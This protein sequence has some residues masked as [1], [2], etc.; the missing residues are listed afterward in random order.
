[1]IVSTRASGA[2]GVPR[3]ADQVVGA[4][5]D[6]VAPR[7]VDVRLHLRNVRGVRALKLEAGAEGEDDHIEARG[8]HLLDRRVEDGLVR[9]GEVEE[10]R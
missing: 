5:L 10:D 1:M 8:G 2:V 6:A 9:G 7:L 3:P 4:D